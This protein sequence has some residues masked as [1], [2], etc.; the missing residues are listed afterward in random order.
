M[1]EQNDELPK[2]RAIRPLDSE[3]LPQIIITDY[4]ETKVVQTL[5]TERH[6]QKKQSRSETRANRLNQPVESKKSSRR[7]SQGSEATYN[8]NVDQKL[9]KAIGNIT[10]QAFPSVTADKLNPNIVKAQKMQSSASYKPQGSEKDSKES[11]SAFSD[12]SDVKRYVTEE[13]N[14]YWD[15]LHTKKYD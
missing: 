12:D 7:S 4:D 15:G 2:K 6:L 14:K 11:D 13:N 8:Y 1:T 3:Q 5:N 10:L 9:D